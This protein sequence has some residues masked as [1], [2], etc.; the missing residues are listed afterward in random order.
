MSL[1]DAH[2]LK[3][4]A[5]VIEHNLL[6]GAWPP[7]DRWSLVW[8]VT[9]RIKIERGNDEGDEAMCDSRDHSEI[10]AQFGLKCATVLP[11]QI[12]HPIMRYNTV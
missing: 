6:S 11:N 7:I 12:M 1:L 4:T 8:T 2:V 5:H 10:K 3:K 9:G